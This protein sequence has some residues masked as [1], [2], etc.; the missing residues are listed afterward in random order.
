M[1]VQNVNRTAQDLGRPRGAPANGGTRPLIFQKT[2]SGLSAQLRDAHFQSLIAGIDA[3]GDRL[4]KRADVK[5]L[6]KYRELI[7]GFLDEV[8]SN[9]YAFSKENAY[10]SRGRHRVFATVKTV[11]AKLNEL[12]KEVFSEQ[13]D[14]LAILGKVGEIHGLLVDIML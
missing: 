14:S 10:A 11:D 7:R 1:K 12:A 9:G 13:A 5:E 6:E 2:M 4:S 8:V 3:Q